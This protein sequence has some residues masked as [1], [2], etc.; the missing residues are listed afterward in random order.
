MRSATI[1][2]AGIAILIIGLVTTAWSVFSG[3]TR[4]YLVLIVPVFA[5]DNIFGMLPLLAVFIGIT[6]IAFAPTFD[7]ANWD[8]A[9]M[10]GTENHHERADRGRSKFGGVVMIGPIPILFGSDKKMTLVAAA[11]AII[12]L[13]IMVLLLL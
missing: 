4:F 12:V 3:M 9:E 7:R 8:V 13:A 1:R 2:R 11:L 6:L 10:D 5:S